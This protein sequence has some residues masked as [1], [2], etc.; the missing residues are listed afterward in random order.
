M[1]FE[2]P[3][4]KDWMTASDV[5]KYLDLTRQR[6]ND[7]IHE[8]RFQTCRRLGNFLVIETWE[9][10]KVRE[11]RDQLLSEVSAGDAIVG[12]TSP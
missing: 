1:R 4:L 11:E 8:G 2:P 7:M 6:V 9:V 10:K 3:E 5:G 12:P